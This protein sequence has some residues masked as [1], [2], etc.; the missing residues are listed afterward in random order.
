MSEEKDGKGRWVGLLAGPAL[1]LFS[2]S[3]IWKNETRF[4]FYRAA[5]KTQQVANLADAQN[6]K[7]I[8]MTGGMDTS[9][10]IQGD[11]VE[12]FTGYTLV[13]RHTEIYAW[14]EEKDDDQTRWTLR[15][16]SSKESN[17]RNG[18][19]RQELESKR[20][21]PP[22]YE[23]GDLTIDSTKIEF[24]DSTNKI[25]V[26]QLAITHRNLQ[27]DGEY[28]YWHKGASDNLG[29]ERVR[30]D[31]IP[32]PET[33]TWF[34]KF[35]QGQGVADTSQQRTGWINMIIMDT[36]VLHHLVAGSRET[37]LG[38]IK[39]YF[40]RLK[41]IV[42]G[43]A[44]ACV[45]LGFFILFATFFGFLFHIPILG[46][47]A[48]YGSLLLAIAIGLPLALITMVL[49]F[50]VANPVSLILIVVGS[51]GLFYWWR[52]SAAKSQQ[53]FEEGLSSRFGEE[54]E[55]L[56]LKELEFIELAQFAMSNDG[57]H[58][59]EEQFLREW[60]RKHKWNDAK[61]QEMLESARQHHSD[62]P[63]VTTEEHLANVIHL[64]LADRNVTPYEIRSIRNLAKNLGYDEATIRQLINKVYES[65]A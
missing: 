44:T 18:G 59:T 10:K 53:K 38:S 27:L 36:G 49:S 19:I 7:N 23:L 6:G 26:D 39:A 9:L 4:D 12:S 22:T 1:V 43:I 35:E 15:W 64:T 61:F 30:Y 31:G 21:T 16:M 54:V 55:V 40:G 57:L 58:E 46:R 62:Q 48:E 5:A 51:G 13:R 32:V 14:D 28:L 63:N 41:W 20:L 2:L 8:S 65:V 47:V 11:Y 60:A 17:S 3:A 56:D 33:A 50:L 34:G 25:P 37:A 52:G 24:V 29:D 42:R 45:I